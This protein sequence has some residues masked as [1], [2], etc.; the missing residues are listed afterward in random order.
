MCLEAFHARV[1][2]SSASVLG[3]IPAPKLN[4]SK[5]PLARTSSKHEGRASFGGAFHPSVAFG[6][7]AVACVRIEFADVAAGV[8]LVDDAHDF[9]RI[10]LAF[11]ELA[12]VADGHYAWSA[13]AY[14]P[15]ELLTEEI[16]GVGH[17]E[18]L[19]H[20]LFEVVFELGHV[21]LDKSDCP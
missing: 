15:H 11:E 5:C 6:W 3:D 4:N 19:R 14:A 17:A 10:D 16:A 21:V 1:L 12:D 2:P 18:V 20:V 13:A 9:L 7:A 8:E